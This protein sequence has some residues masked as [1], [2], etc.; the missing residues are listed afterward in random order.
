MTSL[1]AKCIREE[2]RFYGLRKFDKKI[3]L[4]SSAADGEE[5]ER[6][7]W[8]GWEDRMSDCESVYRLEEAVAG[9]ANMEHAVALNGVVTAVH[10]T[11]RLAAQRL[12]GSSGEVFTLDSPGM[13]EAV[14]TRGMGGSLFGKRAFCPSLAPTAAVNSIIR[15]G[16]E[17][18]FIDASPDDWG[19]DPQALELAFQKYPDVKLT[20]FAHLYGFPG[21]VA[22]IKE[23]CEG[24]GALLIEDASESPWAKYKGRPTGSFGDYGIFGFGRDKMI[25]MIGAGSGGVLLTNDAH[26]AAKAKKWAAQSGGNALWS[27]G[28]EPGTNCRMSDFAAGALLG[29]WRLLE[30][31]I[32]GKKRIYDYYANRLEPLGVELNPY[33]AKDSRPSYWQSCMRL[34]ENSLCLSE[35][36]GC[37]RTYR[38]EHGRTCPLEILESLEAFSVES[39]LI[40]KPMHLQ[41]MCQNYDFI[42]VDGG[43]REYDGRYSGLMERADES[44]GLYA[45]GICL[46]SD[47]QMTQEEQERVIEII[48]AC[49]CERNFGRMELEAAR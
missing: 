8:A 42:S 27:H 26:G 11:V 28:G 7:R 40:F 21:Q 30:E 10:M 4:L 3:C 37:S 17:P 39:A 15:E 13:G 20:V 31:R 12:Y 35:M 36:R 38:D 44:K 6:V 29:R 32:A 25:K 33:D 19:M 16:G 22:R 9:Y 45:K 5:L 1:A 43:R 14:L 18:V 49:F 24:H 23:I 2:P 46:P 34:D 47:V 48:Y 41:P